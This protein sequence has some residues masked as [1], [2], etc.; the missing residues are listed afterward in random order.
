MKDPRPLHRAVA[1]AARRPALVLALTVLL[2]LAGLACATQLRTDAGIDTLVGTEGRSYEAT[3]TYRERFGDDPIIVLVRGPLTKLLLSQDLERVLGLE[4]CISGNAPAGAAVPGGANGP[5]G[6][7]ARDKPVKVVFGP[8]T[9][10]NEAVRQLGTGFAR[11]VQENAAQATAAA[12]RARRAARRRGASPAGA[13]RAAAEARRKV[14]SAFQGEVVELAVRYG[15]RAVPRLD[16]PNFVSTL[17]FD[18]A[19]PA[20]TPK[21]KFAYLFPSKDGGPGDT[22]LIQVRLKAGLSEAQRGDALRDIRAAVTMPEWKPRN[23]ATYTV[24][25]A[26][27]V[28]TDLAAS[29]SGAMWVL[30]VVALLVMALTLALVFGGRPRLLALGVALVATALTFGVLALAGASLTMASIA[31]LP[32]LI[33]LAVDYAIQLQARVEE[34]ARLGA[35]AVAPAARRAALLGAPA[36]AVGAAATAAGFAALAL[37]PVPMVRG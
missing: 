22:A 26:P 18:P 7:L 21:R 33:G 6:R 20:G 3:A 24:T 4:G 11:R 28:V 10:I 36:V 32:V 34:E 14:E 25:G 30:L 15:L 19:K 17:V 5:C 37:S 9:F 1:F 23:G 35:M 27:V 2:A 31:V 13:Q 12:D 8:G 16:D 29:I